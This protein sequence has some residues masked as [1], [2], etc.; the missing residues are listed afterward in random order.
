[1][2]K[3]QDPAKPTPDSE[4]FKPQNVAKGKELPGRQERDMLDVPRGSEPDRLGAAK[5][6][7]T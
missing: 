5:R 1:M 4:K 6:T 7:R 3:T 2:S